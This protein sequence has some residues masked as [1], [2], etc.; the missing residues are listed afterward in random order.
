MSRQV[1][2]ALGIAVEYHLAEGGKV[3]LVGEVA[4]HAL[5][6][7]GK[8]LGSDIGVVGAIEQVVG[9]G[10]GEQGAYDLG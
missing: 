9:G 4:L 1:E 3:G 5:E 7:R 10:D 6:A 2:E 8:G